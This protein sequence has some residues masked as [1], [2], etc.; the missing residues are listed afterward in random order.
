[1]SLARN[2]AKN[3][4]Y[5]TIGKII[6]TVLGVTTIALLLRY[7]SPDDYG[8]YT[9]AI[10]FVLLLGTITDFGLNLTTTQDISLPNADTAR[11]VSSVFTFRLLANV[12]LAAL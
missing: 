7:L 8:R 9:T 2:I 10:A 5:L 12:V 3:T 11:T 4:A 1:M 6:Y